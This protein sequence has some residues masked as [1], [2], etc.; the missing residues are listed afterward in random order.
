MS[1]EPAYDG[2]RFQHELQWQFCMSISPLK[3]GF[4]ASGNGSSARAIVAAIN[5]GKLDAEARLLVSNNKSAAI[6]GF[7]AGRGRLA[8]AL[9]CD[10]DQSGRC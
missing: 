6:L 2:L 8:C 5:S 7:T 4:L 10:P 3:L 1:G 9:Y